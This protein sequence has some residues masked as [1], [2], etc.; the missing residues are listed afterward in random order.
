MKI[1]QLLFYKPIY[2]KLS[3]TLDVDFFLNE[4]YAPDPNRFISNF[5]LRLFSPFTILV[6]SFSSVSF[7]F[8]S[9]VFKWKTLSI[10]SFF[11]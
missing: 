11:F 3:I 1:R 5:I 7:N 2:Q 9:E 10:S 4:R 8:F 6:F